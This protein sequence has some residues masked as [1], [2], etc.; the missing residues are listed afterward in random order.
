MNKKITPTL[1]LSLLVLLALACGGTAPS[2]APQS[3]PTDTPDVQATIDAALAAT[4]AAQANVQA[5]VDAAV[6]ATSAAAPPAPTAVPTLASAEMSEEE[7][8]AL[9]NQA[10][11]DAVA[12]TQQAST[13]TTQAAADDSLTYDEAQTVE[14]YVAG[15]EQ[16]I[17]YAE[18]LIDLYDSLYGE[19][20]TETVE[21]LLAVEDD[22]ENMAT[23]M[24]A[25]AEV[26]AEVE[27]DLAQGVAMTAEALMQL[28]NAAQQASANLEQAQ[29]RAQDWAQGAQSG[30]E[31]RA[32]AIASIQPDNAPTDR[33]S[34]LQS[35]F[36][37]VDEVRAALADN[38]L[39]RDEL[40]RI[41][42]L[43]ANASAGLN[44]HGGQQLKGLSGKVNEITQQ[45]ARGQLPQARNGLG[46]F[47]ASL[48][49]RPAS[50]P[51]PGGGGLSR[52]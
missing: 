30:R 50:M 4:S 27:D 5:T 19:L 31:Q 38:K 28:E 36:T 21:L 18:E 15:A 44:K 1:L 20:A 42:Q 29:T 37:F 22:L 46:N 16:A 43:G 47:E 17:A 35:A 23:A 9:I 11:N 25:V 12:A 41:G 10:V 3:A 13:T 45:L 49:Q 32:N 40:D 34:A 24:Y 39:S 2:A 6:V 33:L 14:V 8:E 7:L 51:Q 52:P 48:G 26:L